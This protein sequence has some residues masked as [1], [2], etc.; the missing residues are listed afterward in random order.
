MPQNFISHSGRLLVPALSEQFFKCGW[1]V[2]LPV[3][4]RKSP[5]NPPFRQFSAKKGPVKFSRKGKKVVDL[6][7]G[8]MALSAEAEAILAPLRE[9]VKEQ[10]SITRI[11]CADMSMYSFCF[12][13][14]WSGN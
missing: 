8:N 5:L 10:V 13:E 3:L 7:F 6:S 11:V 9:A 4:C 1:V 14:I 12:R 2:A